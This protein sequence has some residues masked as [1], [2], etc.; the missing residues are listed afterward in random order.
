MI[1]VR[2]FHRAWRGTVCLST[3]N[4]A[5]T[6]GP[7][8][9]GLRSY[10]GQSLSQG[11][12]ALYEKNSDSSDSVKMCLGNIVTNENIS[13]LYLFD[14][15]TN[16]IAC[17]Q[18]LISPYGDEVDW[19]K[20]ES[21]VK[22]LHN[23]HIF[24]N[25]IGCYILQQCRL[26]KLY[27]AAGSYFKYLLAKKKL[28]QI[29]LNEFCSTMIDSPDDFTNFHKLIYDLGMLYGNRQENLL[30]ICL[31]PLFY[32]PAYY[33]L[34]LEYFEK[35]P[36]NLNINYHV[37]CGALLNNDLQTALKYLRHYNDSMH[38]LIKNF[39]EYFCKN[40]VRDDKYILE[41]MDILSSNNVE[42]TTDLFD[43][44]FAKMDKVDKKF[45]WFVGEVKT[46][47]GVCSYCSGLVPCEFITDTEVEVLRDAFEKDV[48]YQSDLN[49]RSHKAEWHKF[50]N[51]LDTAQY[52]I[53]FDELNIVHCMR[54]DSA[55]CI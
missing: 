24:N 47:K 53:V 48:V 12:E 32:S 18:E 16:R 52:N 34:C 7:G 10:C 17:I 40:G 54:T 39:V 22:E 14:S 31:K 25:M 37:I 15:H 13:K 28:T 23:F 41:F 33:K 6:A 20:I 9:V 2:L 19:D 11:I 8:S 5:R 4:S 26:D 3:V 35:A 45:K 55:V 42:V 46:I 30:R 36:G 44:L 29:I 21:L 49:L 43:K 38:S 50:I 51:F 27:H 1:A